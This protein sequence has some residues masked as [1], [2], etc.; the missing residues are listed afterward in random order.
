MS[1][2]F[3]LPTKETQT[4]EYISFFYFDIMNDYLDNLDNINYL[5]NFDT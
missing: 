2:L 3:S 1:I 4:F 5:D